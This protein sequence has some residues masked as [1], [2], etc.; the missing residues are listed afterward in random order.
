[1]PFIELISLKKTFN[2]HELINK[3]IASLL[4]IACFLF[5]IT[6]IDVF[7]TDVFSFLPAE[8]K[9]SVEKN[10]V[11]TTRIA[12][13]DTQNRHSMTGNESISGSFQAKYKRLKSLSFYFV[14]SSS[15]SASGSITLTI[16][17]QN[18]TNLE[19][20]EFS[21]SSIRNLLPTTYTFGSGAQSAENWI[22]SSGVKQETESLMLE[23]GKIYRFTLAAKNVE[24]KGNL[25]LVLYSDDEPRMIV[26]Y[27]D[28]GKRK[29]GYCFLILLAALVFTWAPLSRLH[30]KLDRIASYSVFFL[31]P[32]VCFIISYIITGIDMDQTLQVM[33]TALSGKYN[34]I[35][36]TLVWLL[37]YTITNRVKYCVILTTF[38]TGLFAITNYVLILFRD[39]PLI[40]TDILS[41][42]TGFAVMES[43]QMRFDLPSMF[44]IVISVAWIAAAISLKSHKGLSLRMRLIPLIIL[45]VGCGAC[46]HQVFQTDHLKEQNIYVNGFKPLL[47]YHTFGYPLSFVMTIKASYMQKPEDYS[48][49]AVEKAMDRYTSDTK[50]EAR[51]VTE[52]TP[53]IIGIM[54]ESFSDLSTLGELRTNEDPMP[55]YHSL[56]KDTIKGTMHSSVY[57]SMTA[58]TEFEFLTG[59]SG[60]FLPYR[61]IAYNNMIKDDIPSET[62]NLKHNGYGGNIAFH[63]GMRTSYNRQEVYPR[64][65]FDRQIALEDLNDPPQIRDFVSD[66]ADYEI[67]EE[68]YRKFR[69][70]S[71]DQ[72]FYLFNVTIQNHGDYLLTNGEVDS[73]IRIEDDAANTEGARQF[74]NL[75][76]ESDLALEKLIKYFSEINEPTVIVLFGDHQPHLEE[77]FYSAVIGKSVE[78]FTAEDLETEYHVPFMIWANYDLPEEDGINLSANYLFPYMQE[79]IGGRLS[80]FDQYL[81]DLYEEIPVITTQGYMDKK[82][83]LYDLEDDSSPYADRILEY[84]MIQYNGMVDSKH[85]NDTFFH[86]Q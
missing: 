52:Q 44:T 84:K 5:L 42:R 73:G 79:R 25:D 56:T 27:R 3:L 65:G 30:S 72:P 70:S 85:R 35:I 21:A 80:A 71:V 11:L 45:V 51:K 54:N 12:L 64:L 78:E 6:Q 81:L 69:Q 83:N 8:S 62:W 26:D 55:F 29:L 37:F 82:G 60:A 20:T 1:M 24:T 58:T 48:A 2:K 49:D 43:Y 34:L 63:P 16:S 9:I 38:I 66:E 15:E 75:M 32:I 14:N 7:R 39:I 33:T 41:A 61:A 47:T 46:Y 86:L 36:L 10:Q 22:I 28:L 67:V 57:G 50:P 77:A 68:E 17:D 53:N 23:P 76:K 59:F 19:T 74:L 13:D 4:L 31:T 18:G 40:A